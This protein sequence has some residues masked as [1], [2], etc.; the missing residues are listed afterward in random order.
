MT[1]NK[2]NKRRSSDEKNAVKIFIKDLHEISNSEGPGCYEFLNMH[3]ETHL[4]PYM[5]SNC[6]TNRKKGELL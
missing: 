2:E 4:Q 5:S 3:F 1:T 6:L